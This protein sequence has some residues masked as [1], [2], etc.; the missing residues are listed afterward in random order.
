MHPIEYLS[1]SR[2][3]LYRK[4]PVMYQKK[5]I[6]KTAVYES[7]PAMSLGSLVH[8][9]V[10]EP[11][12]VDTRFAVA[13]V[14]DK[15]TKAG[16]DAFAEFKENLSADTIIVTH[17]DVDQANRMISAI[18]D[19]PAA[20]E[21]LN[22]KCSVKEDEILRPVGI[23]GKH[24]NCK[25]IPDAYSADKGFLV[26]LKTVSA[27]D[28]LDWAKECH[29]SGYLRQLA[30]YR[31]FLR[32]LGIP[33]TRCVHIVVD[34]GEYPS[35]MVAEFESSDIDKAENQVFETIRKMLDSHATGVFQHPYYGTVPKI[36]VPPWA[37]R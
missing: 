23:D 36:T 5:Y 3:E 26:D 2:I 24:I 27:F 15:R 8:A 16:K 19:N 4:N 17:D 10:L 29:F 13:P 21:F 37:W 28:P 34:K 32:Y 6:E 31:F 12:T 7:T 1:H 14:L 30:F 35:C 20:A 11:T 9:M 25:I 18:G 33:I 22:S